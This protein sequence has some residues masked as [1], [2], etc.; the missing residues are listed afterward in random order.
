MQY[1]R[2]MGRKAVNAF[3]SA[4]AYK[5]D[6]ALS[7]A[8]DLIDIEGW[9]RIFTAL[10]GKAPRKRGAEEK[11]LRLVRD[12]AQGLDESVV[13]WQRRRVAEE[14]ELAG[15]KPPALRSYSG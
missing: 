14:F 1:Q 2:F 6:D 11:A 8:C 9:S 7:V 12:L 3:L 15:G 5:L 13:A 10:D 4:R